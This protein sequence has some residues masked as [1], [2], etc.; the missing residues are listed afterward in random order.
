[1]AVAAAMEGVRIRTVM[2]CLTA[3]K[4]PRASIRTTLT[5]TAT[6]S[7]M[8]LTM[9]TATECRTVR[10]VAAQRAAGITGQVGARE[11]AAQVAGKDEAV[12]CSTVVGRSIHLSGL[13]A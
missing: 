12:I 10:R 7:L 13:A 1:M 3:R 8:A 11:A 9:P 2:A 4:R 6:V 5:L